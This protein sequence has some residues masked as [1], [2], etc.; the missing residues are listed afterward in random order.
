MYRYSSYVAIAAPLGYISPIISRTAHI[1]KEASSQEASTGYAFS[2]LFFLEGLADLPFLPDIANQIRTWLQGLLPWL[3]AGRGGFCA[4][5]FPHQLEGF[6]LAD[7]FRNV[8]AHRRGQDLIALDDS[9][10]IDDEAA[11]GLN[12]AIL[13]IDSIGFTDASILVGKHGEGNPS[14][15]HFGKLMV[16]PH[17]MDEDA[18]HAHREDLDSQFFE[19]LV[20]GSNC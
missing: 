18:V 4:F 12:P 9:V 20:F 8:P 17:L 1:K 15:Y 10:R 6:Y 7:A 14:I 16:I 19:Y 11:P 13:V 5:G 3:P 2:V